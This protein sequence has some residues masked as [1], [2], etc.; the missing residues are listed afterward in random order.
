MTEA[1][2]GAD[3]LLRVVLV[4]ILPVIA[5]IIGATIAAFRRPGPVMRSH[6][7]HLAAGVVFSVVAVEILPDVVH[8]QHPW[9]LVIGFS[10][11][12]ALM[13]GLEWFAARAEGHG[14]GKETSSSHAVL[15]ASLGIDVFLDGLLIAISFNAGAK[16][17]QL[18][19]FALAVELLSTGLALSAT[20]GASGMKP[21]RIVVTSTAVFSLIVAGAT[22][23]ALLTPL[24]TGMLLDLILSFGLA[25]LLFLVVEQLLVEAHKEPETPLSTA[26]FFIGFLVFLLL[27][28]E[29]P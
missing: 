16:A 7:Q 9:L 25:A 6:I 17:G 20:L 5:A 4:S 11:G 27:G 10:L 23:G 12:V 21:A 8:R 28:M 15:F 18:L 2:T 19:T 3:L 1:S 14:S 22:A 24:L 29:A 13:L 26:L